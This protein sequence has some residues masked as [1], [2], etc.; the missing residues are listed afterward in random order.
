MM[1]KIRGVVQCVNEEAREEIVMQL[2]QRTS[3]K[4]RT[5]SAGLNKTKNRIRIDYFL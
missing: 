1:K 4:A 5:F 2:N 3:C